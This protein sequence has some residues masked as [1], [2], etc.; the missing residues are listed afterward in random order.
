MREYPTNLIGL[1]SDHLS[2]LSILALHPAQ[3]QPATAKCQN[4]LVRCKLWRLKGL[5]DGGLFGRIF[6]GEANSAKSKKGLGIT[7]E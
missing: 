3:T 6:T 4:R 2:R 1:N 7:E 5:P